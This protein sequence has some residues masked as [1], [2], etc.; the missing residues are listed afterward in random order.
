MT[1]TVATPSAPRT[2]GRPRTALVAVTT[3][4]T[5]A[6]GALVPAAPANAAPH[7]A[8]GTAVLPFASTMPARSFDPYVDGSPTV[9]GTLTVRLAPLPSGA[10]GGTVAVQWHQVN[11][12]TLLNAPIA[13]ATSLT[14][15]PTAA[16][17][18]K[19]LRAVVTYSAP[20]YNTVESPTALVSI[21]T[22]APVPTV[23]PSLPRT[24]V[25]TRFSVDPGTWPGFLSYSVRYFIDGE[26][27]PTVV[28]APPFAYV[29]RSLT[30]LLYVRTETGTAIVRTAPTV[31][32]AGTH[33][34]AVQ[35]SITS[36]PRVGAN[37]ELRATQLASTGSSVSSRHRSIVWLIDGQPVS[38]AS[39]YVPTIA[40]LG[41]SITVRE[42]ITT[43][44]FATFVATTAPA[45]VVKGNLVRTVR[46]TASRDAATVGS[47]VYLW[48]SQPATAIGEKL[49]IVWTVGGTEVPATLGPNSN[50][51]TYSPKPEDQ[52]KTVG[53]KVTFT[54]PGYE[55]LVV[56]TDTLTVVAGSMIHVAPPEITGDAVVGATI[57][58]SVGTWYPSGDGD[59]LITYTTRWLRNGAAIAGTT[60][61]STA[62]RA[63]YTLTADDAG[64]G[65]TFEVTASSPGYTA[66][67]QTS[68]AVRVTLPVIA[69]RVAPV[70]TGAARLGETLTAT[71]GAW[72]TSPNRTTIQWLRDG[73]AI[74][75]ATA[76]RY[77][78][79]TPDVGRRL[80]VRVTAEAAGHRPATVTSA[81]VTVAPGTLKATS[82]P[83]VSGT[84]SVG[85][86]LTASAGT[87]SVT[88]TALSYQWL[89][90]GRAV[91]GATK[92]SYAVTKADIGSVLSVRVTASAPGR[93]SA[94]ATSAA[95]AK[96]AKV[97]P[98]VSVS[99][100][101]SVKATARARITVKVTAPQVTT[102][103]A[104]TVTITW[105]SGAKRKATVALKAGHQGTLTY[106]LPKLAK[107]KRT[108]TVSYAPAATDATHLTTAKSSRTLTIR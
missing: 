32:V 28:S 87:W 60:R 29:G 46:L 12:N 74:A 99:A 68:A 55:D 81:S 23:A 34:A 7:Q 104:G 47:S 35:P 96:V 33:V 26:P 18:G 58:G 14:Y 100:P 73:A 57:T 80:A 105:G 56:R 22:V 92:A 69:A 21:G 51:V 107:G 27:I 8:A 37:V 4:V 17:L 85:K 10:T 66:A 42:T 86:I 62:S 45:T 1:H 25:G 38:T 19:R 30:A 44:G 79:T 84:A 71:T 50:Y 64:A 24:G 6:L 36:T 3:A 63:T 5:L 91:A 2:S 9:G 101:A 31:I 61:T 41:K 13:G 20:G 52:G 11:E 59:A 76:T 48:L 65:I 102:A 78:P 70:V 82:A 95:T 77:T 75:G 106:R 94:T 98:S 88:G 83:R 15:Q 93:S 43:P 103:P 90:S 40:D 39:R 97:T 108:V 89:R 16:D 67:S 54:A 53:A 49:S 72:S